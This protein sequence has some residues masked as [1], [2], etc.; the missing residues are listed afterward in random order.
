[1]RK[2]FKEKTAEEEVMVNSSAKGKEILEDVIGDS[3]GIAKDMEVNEVRGLD[4]N[5]LNDE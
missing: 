3:S 4:D 5:M 1:M 2:Y